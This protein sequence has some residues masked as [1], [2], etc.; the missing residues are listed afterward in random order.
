TTNCDVLAEL[1]TGLTDDISNGNNGTVL[2]ASAN[3][4]FWYGLVTNYTFD[5]QKNWSFNVGTDLRFYEGDHFQQLIDLLGAK[6][7]RAG[8]ADYNVNR[9]TRS[10]ERRVGKASCYTG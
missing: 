9:S 10:E 6:G 1:N 2:R 7:R 3:I 4:H 5:T 8:S